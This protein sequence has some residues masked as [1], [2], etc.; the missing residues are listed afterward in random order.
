MHCERTSQCRYEALPAA[1]V[2]ILSDCE[3]RWLY[4]KY[5]KIFWQH[6]KV[7]R[8]TLAVKT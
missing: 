7:L 8:G 2:E 3:V 6:V 1:L 5:R 4:E